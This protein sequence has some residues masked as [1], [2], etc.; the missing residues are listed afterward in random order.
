MATV[1]TPTKNQFRTMI[2]NGTNTDGTAR[3]A[4]ISW[5]ALKPSLDFTDS[6]NSAKLVALT[7]ALAPCLAF[8]V[9]GSQLVATS[10]IVD[11][12]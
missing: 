4:T 1:V 6:T 7:T 3:I 11:E 5:N 10:T 9:V 8:S 12:Q 2:Q